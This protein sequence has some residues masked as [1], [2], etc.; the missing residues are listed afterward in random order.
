MNADRISE[1]EY[2]HPKLKTLL[3][4]KF[5]A[6]LLTFIAYLRHAPKTVQDILAPYAVFLADD[7]FNENKTIQRA[8]EKLKRIKPIFPS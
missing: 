5:G 3:N 4:E 8:L 1:Q 7:K 2:R 6:E